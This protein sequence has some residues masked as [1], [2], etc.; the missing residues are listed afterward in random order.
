M[1]RATKPVGQTLR[2]VN[3]RFYAQTESI[4]I[5]TECE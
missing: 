4:L 3:W 1:T 2:S 5:E